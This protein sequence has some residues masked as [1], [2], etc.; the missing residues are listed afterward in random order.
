LTGKART[1]AF[2][3]KMLRIYEDASSQMKF[4]CL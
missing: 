4:C 2:N 1:S 3:E